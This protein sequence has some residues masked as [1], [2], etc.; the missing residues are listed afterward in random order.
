MR[1]FQG[2]LLVILLYAL[3]T[4]GLPVHHRTKHKLR[5]IRNGGSNIHKKRPFF[6]P[7]PSFKTFPRRHVFVAA[8]YNPNESPTEFGYRSALSQLGLQRSQLNVTFS[9]TDSANVTHIY[10]KHIVHNTEVSNHHAAIHV[11][12]GRV[13]AFS[14]SFGA[15]SKLEKRHQGVH[16][17]VATVPEST[18]IYIAQDYFGLPHHQK[19]RVKFKYVEIPSGDLVYAYVIQL[20]DANS[21]IQVHVDALHGVF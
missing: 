8:S 19:H 6:H 20:K 11:R 5:Y 7:R 3:A 2:P 10:L 12:D 9:F 14:A 15:P 16:P 17:P 21:W 1:V 18:A 4:A 13:I